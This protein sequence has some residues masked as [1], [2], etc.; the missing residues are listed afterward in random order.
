MTYEIPKNAVILEINSEYTQGDTDSDDPLYGLHIRTDNGDIKLLINPDSN[1]C[2]DYGC[3][4]LETPDDISKFIG[5]KIIEVSDIA[6]VNYKEDYDCG[7]ETQLKIVTNRG[8]LQYAVY[9]D[10][11]GYYSHATFTQ[12]FE[13]QCEDCL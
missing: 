6:T 1:C 3:E 2:E 12:V 13:H 7:G 8:V 10:H 5:A 4:F 11:N 9:N